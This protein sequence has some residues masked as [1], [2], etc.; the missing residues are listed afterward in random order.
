MGSS[1]SALVERY[2]AA[3]NAHD[4]AAVAGTFAADGTVVDPSGGPLE[5]GAISG[6]VERTCRAFPDLV[7]ERGETLESASGRVV[8]W[9]TMRGTNDGALRDGIAPT[10]RAVVLD[11]LDVF[12]VGDAGI[13]RVRRWFDANALHDRLG[14]MTLVQPVEQGKAKYGYAMRVPSGNRNVPGVIALTWI[15]GAN[16]GE[17]ERIRA[18]ARENVQDFLAE[19]GFIGIVTG[20]TGLRGFT[21][22]AW[23]DEPAMKRALSKHHAVAMREL[24][25]ERFVASVWTSVWTPSRINRVWV[26]CTACGSLEDV[27]VERAACSACGGALPERPELW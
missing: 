26:R 6:W 8:V 25:G 27:S 18:H 2:F 5:G 12:D 22:T 13:L 17:K 3:W 15:Q 10:A 1:A 11:G 16:E 20:F 24:F 7:F 23:E 19:P 9:W 14:L 4:G 21:V